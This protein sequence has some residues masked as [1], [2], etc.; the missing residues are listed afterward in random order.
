MWSALQV[1]ITADGRDAMK[2]TNYESQ[3]TNHFSHRFAMLG[4]IESPVTGH[5]SQVTKHGH[6]N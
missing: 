1:T 6:F 3:I 5:Q 2:R 4:T